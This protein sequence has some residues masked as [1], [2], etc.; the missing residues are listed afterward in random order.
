MESGSVNESES[1]ET[2]LCE[3]QKVSVDTPPL[4]GYIEWLFNSECY[5]SYF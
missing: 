2:G 3:W 5:F 1:P 4:C